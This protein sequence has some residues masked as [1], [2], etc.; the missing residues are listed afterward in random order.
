MAYTNEQKEQR[1]LAMEL[2]D[3]VI[4]KIYDGKIKEAEVAGT[5]AREIFE[6]LG[7]RRQVA[8]SLNLLSIV[9]AE[10][11]NE[12]IDLECLLEGLDICIDEDAY[13]IAAKI[14]NNIGSKF[15]LAKDFERALYYFKNSNESYEKAC[16][17]QLFSE[18]N[19]SSFIIILELNLAYAYSILG[20]K[21]KA[22]IYYE[23][24]K[25]LSTRPENAD[26]D[27]I[28]R[29][30]E[31]VIL[32]K[33][34][35]HELARKLAE[36]ILE[37]ASNTEYI[38][39]YMEIMSYLIELLKEMKDY[40]KL[41]RAISLLEEHNKSDVGLFVKLEILNY[42]VEYYKLIGDDENFRK[43]CIR[44]YEMSREKM[45]QDNHKR[46]DEIEIKAEIRRTK[47]EKK[48]TDSIVFV[49]LLT[50]IGN[51]N[52]MLQDSKLY[53]AD[54]VKNKTTITIGL[55]DI[56]F[57]KECNDTYGHIEGDNCLKAVAEIIKAAV[58]DLG[59]VYR[60]GG[61]E[62]LLLLPDA[63]KEDIEKIGSTIKDNLEKLKIENKKSPINSC[64]TVSQGYTMARAEEGDTIEQLV[65]LADRV[66]YS[67][68]RCG[69]NNYKYVH[70]NDIIAGLK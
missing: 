58:G 26:L 35:E 29:A 38:T 56:D 62:F 50:Q 20:E 7:D 31:G 25:V 10:M 51:R 18:E 23:K 64:V 66:L 6:E 48:K 17:R 13:D 3:E 2:L 11:G 12:T 9:Y 27:L 59:N 68:K 28:F 69:K 44:Y 65:N 34:G 67:V 8:A 21:E 55:I 15:M 70:F 60:Y 36:D 53:I 45:V 46:A 33:I 39:D 19:G 30:F 22:R 16:E 5:R 57:F 52:K 40:P 43:A 42:R 61:D 54:S 24:A 32:W 41:E 37:T 14:Y 47:R 63:T 49:D 1:Q 4:P